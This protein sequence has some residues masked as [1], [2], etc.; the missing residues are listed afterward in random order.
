MPQ[1]VVSTMDYIGPARKIYSRTLK[2]PIV[3]IYIV[4]P[5]DNRD[6][7]NNL[8]IN[9][10]ILQ[11]IMPNLREFYLIFRC[12]FEAKDFSHF[13]EIEAALSKEAEAFLKF[14]THWYWSGKFRTL[15]FSNQLMKTVDARPLHTKK[16]GMGA[17]EAPKFGVEHILWSFIL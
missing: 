17:M 10:R 2:V 16:Q 1:R 8:G 14:I 3:S 12:K 13:E 5:G 6:Y 4:R 7:E 11:K 9:L 15:I